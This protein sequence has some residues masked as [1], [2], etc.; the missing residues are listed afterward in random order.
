M[1][2]SGIDIISCGMQTDGKKALG[3]VLCNR[4]DLERGADEILVTLHAQPFPRRH[5]SI[6]SNST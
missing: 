4:R 1:L 5:S 3:R 6:S 2:F